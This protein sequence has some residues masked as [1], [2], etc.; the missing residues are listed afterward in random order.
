MHELSLCM[1][2]IR[3]IEDH[4]RRQPLLDLLHQVHRHD[5]LERRLLEL[6]AQ[7]GEIDV[8]EVIARRRLLHFRRIR[9]HRE[10]DH[11]VQV[12]QQAADVGRLAR[13]LQLVLPDRLL[14][15]PDLVLRVRAFE[16]NQLTTGAQQGSRQRDERAQ[17]THGTSGHRIQ[18]RPTC[19]VFATRT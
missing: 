11:V 18:H 13:I 5:I 17:C 1:E 10:I 3:V 7:A 16:K 6:G 4:H 8:R 15:R 9:T 2:L 19:P 14:S 12:L